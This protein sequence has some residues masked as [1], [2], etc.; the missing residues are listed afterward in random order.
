MRI[1]PDKI[2]VALAAMHDTTYLLWQLLL[3]YGDLVPDMDCG[4][5]DPWE[6]LVIEDRE[7]DLIGHGIDRCLLETGAIVK[8]LQLCV[9]AEV[10]CDLNLVAPNLKERIIEGLRSGRFSRWPSVAKAM[11]AALDERVHCGAEVRAAVCDA[12]ARPIVRTLTGL[13]GEHR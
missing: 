3:D 10:I 12:I 5:F 4:S 2:D 11:Q 1:I 13:W 7:E 9:E 8:I 6:F